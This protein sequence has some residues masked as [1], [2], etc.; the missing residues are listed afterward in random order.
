MNSKKN[1]EINELQEKEIHVIAEIVNFD[2]F[3]L[4]LESE[5]L[6]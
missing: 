3:S 1:K 2:R 5:V 4:Y 6:K